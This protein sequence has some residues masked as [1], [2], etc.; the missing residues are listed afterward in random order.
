MIYA[1]LPIAYDIDTICPTKDAINLEYI[2]PYL[3][4]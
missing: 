2:L 4:M 3:V 1:T